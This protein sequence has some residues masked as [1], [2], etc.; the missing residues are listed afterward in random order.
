[1]L[2]Q[3]L[4][5]ACLLVMAYTWL[6]YPC[7]LG[8]VSTVGEHPA[9][10]AERYPTVGVLFSAHNEED[11]VRARIENLL[12][13][14]YPADHVRIYAGADGCTDG[15]V[16]VLQELALIHPALHVEVAERCG[17]KIA[18]LKR[19]AGQSR[20]ELLLFTDANTT[21]EPDA[22][23]Q[24]VQHV[25]DPT[26]GGVCGRLVLH[27]GEGH[28]TDEGLY[29]RWESRMKARE[30]RIDSCLGANG[31]IYCLRRPL[32]WDEIPDNTIVDDLVVGMKVR[33]RGFRMLYEPTAVAHEELP[34]RVRDE[35][36]RRVRIG[37][38]DYQALGLCRR[39]L[40]PLY[41]AFAW[42]FW[43]HK[44][45]RWYTPHLAVVALLAALGAVAPSLG[46]PPE[47]LFRACLAQAP[48]ATGV[49]CAA[50]AALV[51]AGLGRILRRVRV[52][53]FAPLRWCDYFVTM[54]AALLVGYVRYRR[55]GLSGA[56]QRTARTGHGN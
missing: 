2:L 18:M 23:M 34:A 37:A 12:A 17:G 28:E 9:P 8:I 38:G 22:V 14:D 25:R 33:E 43:S 13:L 19:L 40:G 53:F 31:A 39:C 29:W 36:A 27:D 55:G 46:A 52:G 3:A 1:M 35:W 10:G 7:L 41:G 42:M 48:L 5:L 50:V 45:L 4:V 16:D 6:L 47:A 44:V 51:G 20:E 11:H 54:Q 24:M 21:F 49:L 32:F 56:W 30:S 26:V 15:T